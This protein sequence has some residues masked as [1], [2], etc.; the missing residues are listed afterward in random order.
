MHLL[1]E[2]ASLVLVRLP[3]RWWWVFLATFGNRDLDPQGVWA[4]RQREVS[5]QVGR[6]KDVDQE[7]SLG[8][9]FRR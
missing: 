1:E 8:L 4:R 2:E 6:M 7:V 9:D 3:S 5:G